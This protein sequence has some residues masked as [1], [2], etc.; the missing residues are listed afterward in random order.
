MIEDSLDLVLRP[1]KVGESLDGSE[2]GSSQQEFGVRA[3]E[4]AGPGS[5]SNTHVHT[6][7]HTA[8]KVVVFLL[9]DKRQRAK[10]HPS[11]T[12]AKSQHAQ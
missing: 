5:S 8:N 9:S 12:T 2:D 1:P 11:A 10:R 4:E 7:A 6:Q 3:D